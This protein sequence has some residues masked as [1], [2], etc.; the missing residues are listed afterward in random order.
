MNEAG[1]E[2]KKLTKKRVE[3]TKRYKCLVPT[4]YNKEV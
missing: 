3:E 2:K 1:V 4:A